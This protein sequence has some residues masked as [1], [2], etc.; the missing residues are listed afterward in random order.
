MSIEQPGEHSEVSTLNTAII[1]LQDQREKKPAKQIAKAPMWK[2]LLCIE[3]LITFTQSV[4]WTCKKIVFNFIHTE[5][6][7][8]MF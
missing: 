1:I 3:L 4:A 7:Q 2:K 5:C 6:L 8:F